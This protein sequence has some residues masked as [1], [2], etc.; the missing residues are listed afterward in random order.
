MIEVFTSEWLRLAGSPIGDPH[1]AAT[2]FFRATHSINSNFRCAAFFLTRTRLFW[3]LRI[4]NFTYIFLGRLVPWYHFKSAQLSGL[5]SRLAPGCESG[6]KLPE[7]LLLRFALFALIA[8]ASYTEIAV[9]TPVICLIQTAACAAE[10]GPEIVENKQRQ[11]K[12]IEEIIVM[13]YNQTE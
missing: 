1:V 13:W 4:G 9:S 8:R 6:E 11:E 12:R 7:E 10:A 3:S 2:A 5:S